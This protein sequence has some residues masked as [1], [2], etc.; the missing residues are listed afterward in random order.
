MTVVNFGVWVEGGRYILFN[1]NNRHDNLTKT[2][3]RNL[4]LN[5]ARKKMLGPSPKNGFLVFGTVKL[6]NSLFQTS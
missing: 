5:R 4:L 6:R 1:N 3:D 2:A